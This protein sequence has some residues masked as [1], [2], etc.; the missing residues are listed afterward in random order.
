[1][2]KQ[3]INN[4]ETG[5]VVRGKLNDNFTEVYD[6]IIELKQKN[7]IIT[8]SGSV[9]LALTDA[10]RF[11]KCTNVTPIDITVPPNST[12]AFPIG[13]EI[14]ITQ[15]AAGTVTLVEGAAVTINSKN[16]NKV[17][18]GQFSKAILKKIDTDV[19]LLTG[20]LTT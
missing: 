10:E 4:Q 18:N 9:T 20:D 1:M 2:A 17:L 7:A 6:D 14:E 19:W 15:Y 5:L 13:T 3:T 16:S 11:L 8:V 12:V